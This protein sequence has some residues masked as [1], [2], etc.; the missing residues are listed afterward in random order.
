[1]IY[2]SK[3]EMLTNRDVNKFV[4]N[5]LEKQAFCVCW[6]FLGSFISAHETWD[7]HFTCCDYIF[8]QHMFKKPIH[9]LSIWVVYVLLNSNNSF[10]PPMHVSI[11]CQNPLPP[12][13]SYQVQDRPA[14]P[15]K[16]LPP[17]PVLKQAQ[18][19]W[20]RPVRWWVAWKMLVCAMQ[21]DEI[22]NLFII[23]YL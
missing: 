5:I 23:I 20:P 14:P 6:T 7:Q 4:Q 16:P 22:S 9:F 13:F 2:L 1:M 8:V 11:G 19:T 18:V 15:T 17:D 12:V 3:G 21:W 10:T